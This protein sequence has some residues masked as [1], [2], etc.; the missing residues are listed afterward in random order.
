MNLI[1]LLT[2]VT[3]LGMY[4]FRLSRP[5]SSTL[6]IVTSMLLFL[7]IESYAQVIISDMGTIETVSEGSIL[8]LESINKAFVPP[9][10][11]TL[12]RNSIPNPLTGAIVYNT[13]LECLQINNG[14]PQIPSWECIGD[15]ATG[16]TGATGPQGERGA[17]GNWRN[18]RTR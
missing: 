4:I 15:G 8:E 9:R 11:T 10:M 18:W 5:R 13:D 6:L 7:S 12:Q 3:I 1:L 16:A 14:T 2:V 17:T